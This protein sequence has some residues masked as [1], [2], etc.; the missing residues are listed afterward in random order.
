MKGITKMDDNEILMRLIN[1]LCFQIRLC[2]EKI[3][4]TKS[5]TDKHFD[6]QMLSELQAKE[7]EAYEAFIK[8]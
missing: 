3:N 6:L 2:R 1:E 8:S 4:K 5:E 7:K